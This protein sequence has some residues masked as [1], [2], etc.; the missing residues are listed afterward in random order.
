MTPIIYI[1]PM[2]ESCAKCPCV[3][4]W[5]YDYDSS[6]PSCSLGVWTGVNHR[7]GFEPFED[8]PRENYYEGFNHTTM[9]HKD[10]PLNPLVL[11]GECAKWKTDNCIRWIWDKDRHAHPDPDD[12]CKDGVKA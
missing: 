3:Y 9:R 4:D 8:E 5:T 7:H 6:V 2:P 12:F 10:C 1:N 11:C